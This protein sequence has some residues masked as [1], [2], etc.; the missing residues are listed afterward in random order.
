MTVARGIAALILG[1]ALVTAVGL[2][3][4]PPSDEAL[5]QRL[6]VLQGHL[7]APKVVDRTE[8]TLSVAT[9]AGRAQFVR[10]PSCDEG[11][12]CSL[13]FELLCWDRVTPA[14]RG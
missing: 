11:L 1:L 10:Q 4:P 9:A 6:L 13:G 5:A 3:S 12:P 2:R 8:D 7:Y 14:R